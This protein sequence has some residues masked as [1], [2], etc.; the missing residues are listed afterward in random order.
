MNAILQSDDDRRL[1]VTADSADFMLR[2][3]ESARVDW[4]RWMGRIE[5][6]IATQDGI[7]AAGA[8]ADLNAARVEYDMAQAGYRELIGL[9]VAAAEASRQVIAQRDMALDELAQRPDAGQMYDQFVSL[10]AAHGDLT[11]EDAQRAAY[12]LFSPDEDVMAN[13]VVDGD[14]A[15]AR[16]RAAFADIVDELKTRKQVRETS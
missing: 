12:I 4:E 3:A 11:P 16:F 1:I 10:L 15:L 5:R 13:A 7:D 9:V 2:F 8:L 14:D 6:F